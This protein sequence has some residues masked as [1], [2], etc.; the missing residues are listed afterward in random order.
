LFW[1]LHQNAS[2]KPEA[3]AVICAPA[4]EVFNVHA[5][6]SITNGS[7]I[8]VIP[9]SSYTPSNNVTGPPQNGQALNACAYLP[10]FAHTACVLKYSSLS[11]VA[12]P[13]QL[14]NRFV[15]ARA[16]ATNS[17]VPGA[18]FRFAIQLDGTGQSTFSDPNGFLNLTQTVYVSTYTLGSF[19]AQS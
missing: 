16:N 8:T 3:K 9:V 5:T 7:L 18:I 2:G 11:V 1:Y 14:G 10:R 4:I 12:D 17:G 6:A 15:A 19:L 13:S